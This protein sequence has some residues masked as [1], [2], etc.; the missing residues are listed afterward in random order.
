MRRARQA[1]T[2]AKQ[3]KNLICEKNNPMQEILHRVIC[4]PLQLLKPRQGKI[5][6][7]AASWLLHKG[8]GTGTACSI[9][10]CFFAYIMDTAKLP[11][12]AKIEKRPK[13]QP[14]K[15]SYLLQGTSNKRKG[16]VHTWL[17]AGNKKSIQNF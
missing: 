1:G 6:P 15:F 2:F 4:P 11:K 14:I 10:C 16:M 7:N 12:Q 3:A 8:S 9:P 17:Y 5:T 13:I